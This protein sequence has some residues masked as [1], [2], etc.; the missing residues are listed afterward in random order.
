MRH[1]QAFPC[2]PVLP[3]ALPD[4]PFSLRRESLGLVVAGG[5]GD[6]FVTM[7]VDSASLGCSELRLFLRLL[8]NLSDLLPLLLWCWDLHPQDDVPNFWLCQWCHIHTVGTQCESHH[9]D[10]FP[11]SLMP[12]TASMLTRWET[13]PMCTLTPDN[14]KWYLYSK[15]EVEIH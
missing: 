6:Y 3:Y 2:P 11:W 14:P 8:L 10:L 13:E 15:C 5:G 1:Q 4:P 7:L 9:N 12:L